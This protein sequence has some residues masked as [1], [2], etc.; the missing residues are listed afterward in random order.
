VG[1]F[2]AV[3]SLLTGYSSMV[4]TVQMMDSAELDCG[5]GEE[6]GTVEGEKG[7]Y[8]T[9]SERGMSM[10]LEGNFSYSF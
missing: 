4:T 5:C 10:L 3:Y 9:G 1:S 7:S 8:L 6:V 2:E